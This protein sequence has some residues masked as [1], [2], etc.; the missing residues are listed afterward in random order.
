MMH[1]IFVGFLSIVIVYNLAN[2]Q[3]D[4]C[5]TAA[6]IGTLGA[7][8]ACPNENGPIQTYNYTTVGATP[9]SPYISLLN[10]NGAPGTGDDMD[11]PAGDVWIRFV[12]SGTVLDVSITS[13]MS[14]MNVG[15]YTGSCGAL[16]GAFCDISTNGNLTTTFEPISPG[17]TY[18]M[19]ISG[20]STTD[21]GAFTLSLE[22]S[23]NCD[24]CNTASTITATPAPVNGFYAPNTTVTFCY[25][26]TNFTQITNNWL[27][28]VVPTFGPGWN[29]ST[30]TPAAPTP[31]SGSIQGT[32]Y[33]WQWD[34]GPTGTG[35]WVDVDPNGPNP[36]DGN[37]TNNFG[38]PTI[39]GSGNWPFCWTI[40]TDAN[41]TQGNDLSM[42]VNTTSDG[43]TGNWNSPA[44]LA[45]P[46]GSFTSTLLCCAT[47][48]NAGTDASVCTT[49]STQ[50]GGSYSN[51]TGS[52]T[53]SWTASPASALTGLSST[54]SLNPTF[55]PPAGLTG[56]VTF[57]LSVTDAACTQTDAVA[58]TIVGPPTISGGTSVCLNNSL[59]LSG[60]GTPATNN[61]WTSSNP[62][63]ATI[64]SGGVVTGVSVGSTTITYTNSIGCSNTLTL[65]VLSL[66][67]ISGT[68]TICGTGTTQLTGSGTPA[69]S[70]PWTSSNNSIATV[71]SSGLVTGIA[72]GTVNITYTNSAGCSKTESITVLPLPTISGNTSVCINNTTQ[73]N[74]SGT[75]ATTNPWATSSASIATVSGTGLVTGVAAGTTSITYT[76]ADGCSVTIPV[77]VNALPTISGTLNACVGLSSNL[78]GSGVASTTNPWTSSNATIAT[79][80]SSGTVTAVSIGSV[81]ITYTNSNGCSVSVNF[82]VNPLPTIS[83]T[84]NV[85]L[86][87]SITLSGT[88]TASATTPWQSSN[89][90]VA[91]VNST[92]VV[93]GASVGNSNITYTNSNGCQASALVAVLALPSVSGT[94]NTCAGNSSTLTG[95]GTPS[96][97]S[98]WISSNAAVATVSS[99]GVV[100][101][102]SAGTTNITYTNSNG[103][104]VTV[105]FTVNPNPTIN[106]A[107][108]SCLPGSSLLTG[109]GTPSGTNPWVSS[110]TTSST[111]NASG[112]VTAVS[113]GTSTITYTNSSGCQVSAVFTV[114]ANPTITGTPSVCVGATSQLT[115]SGAAASVN[116]WVSSSTIIATVNSTG[117]VS[118]LSPGTTTITF[119]D[120]NGCQ[121]NVTFTVNAL[122]SAAIS[123]GNA[124]C[125]GVTPAPI[126][127]SV[128]GSP[129]WTVTYTLNGTPGSISG[130][131]SPIS[132]GNTAGTYVL[133]GISDALCS[134]SAS[135]TQVI[136]FSPAPI[137]SLSSN[138]PTVCNGT[139]GSIVVSG[140]GNGNL[141]W[142]G[143]ISGSQTNITLPF[144]ISNLNAGTY[145]VTFTNTA[146]GCSTLPT[147]ASLN[148]PGAP[149]INVINDVS[150]CG[151]SYTLPV[152]TGVSL[153]NA[154]YYTLPGGPSGGGTVV[155]SGTVLSTTGTVSLYAYD[156]NGACFD[157]EP[158]TVTIQALPNATLSGGGTFCSG[159][160]ISPVIAN[161]TGT[162]PFTIQY[163]L[164]G[165]TFTLNSSSLNQSLGTNAGSYTLLSVS[166]ANCSNTVNGSSSITINPLPSAVITGGGTYCANQAVTPVSVTTTGS[167][168]WL[169]NYTLNGTAQ[170]VSGNSSPISL[171]SSAGTYTITTVTDANCSS[172]ANG[173]A[174]IIIHPLPSATISGGGN[175]CLGTSPTPIS[176]NLSGSPQ[177]SITY[178]ID[179]VPTTVNTSNNVLNVGS[180]AG[181]YTLVSLTDA[182]CS[183]NISGTQS[184]SITSLPTATISG[185]AT[186]CAGEII[187]N[188]VAAVSGAGNW[189]VNYTLNGVPA[190]ASANSSPITIGNTAGTYVLTGISDN[191]CNAS[192]TGSTSIVINPLPT[193]TILGGG[194]FC[195]GNTVN[196]VQVSFTG[197]PSWTLNYTFNGVPQ[198]LN[199]AGNSISLGTQGGTYVLTG[200]SDAVCNN[201]AVGSQDIV[202]NALPSATIT[203]GG[204]F[205]TGS[206]ITPVSA[207]VTG[208]GNWQVSYTLNGIPGTA[209]GNSSPIQ[210]NTASGNYLL[211]SVSD[212]NCTNTA[213]GNTEIVVLPLPTATLSGGATYCAGETIESILVTV[214]GSPNFTIDYLLDGVPGTVLGTTNSFPLGTTAGT[215]ALVG[216]SDASCSNT[217]NGSST[218]LIHPIPA[219]SI[220]GND[221]SVCNATDGFVT[222]TGLTA[223]NT[224]GLSYTVNGNPAAD[225]LLSDATG[226]F[227]ISGLTAGEYAA[228][229]V[230][231]LSTDCQGTNP[232]VITLI[233]PGAPF[234]DPLQD[235]IGCDSIVLPGISGQNLTVNVGYFTGIN[236]TGIQYQPGD[237][238]F[239]GDSL[240]IFDGIGTCTAQIGLQVVVDYTPELNQPADLVSCGTAELPVIT[241]NNLSGN[242]T[243][244]DDAQA[245]GGLP[246]IGNMITQS[247][248]I[249]IYDAVNGCSDETSF[250][251]TIHPLPVLDSVFGG[252][253]YC[254][255]DDIDSVAVSVSGE[256]P[257]NVVFSLNGTLDTLVTQTTTF[258]IGNT[259]GEYEV[260][261][262][263]SSNCST[264]VDGL[265]SIIVNE[266]PPAPQT[267][268]DTTYCLNWTPVEMS[269]QGSGGQLT[270]YAD[271]TFSTIIDETPEIVAGTT[272]YYVIEELNGCIG[273][274]SAV[275]I[276][277]NACEIE[278]P[279][280]FTPDG[281]FRN[282]IWQI[283]DIDVI[284]PKNIVRIYNRWGNLL[285]ESAEGSY[286]S[287]PWNGR[288]DDQPLPVGSYYFIIELNEP[289]LEPLKGIVSI[290]LN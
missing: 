104:P 235:I 180:A 282:D 230:T 102:I 140:S 191:A 132:L 248:T 181:T 213:F 245:A 76:N 45:D 216:I 71:S 150:L 178:T 5:A 58:V 106:G 118:G 159:N 182:V 78:T 112:L 155:P 90:A 124:Y 226:S 60:T 42:S 147:T 207:Q 204:T 17:T 107:L 174:N 161:L 119:T 44:C 165:N 113:P 278:I 65:N 108:S 271:S 261:S 143:S 133:T 34:T 269:A 166:D 4:N 156:A 39:N 110:N 158:F 3:G 212:A 263:Y 43:E 220:I 218:I 187:G 170:T 179:G 41:C 208:V 173:N 35:W 135:G 74:G 242:A 274:A 142:S 40:T 186:Y 125:A 67:T 52:V 81:T 280:A 2:G 285:F 115:G 146:T 57:T 127:V 189:T 98:P 225:T 272:T 290:I 233:N 48:V 268:G 249:W 250:V 97:S 62:A 210:L 256:T 111:I 279:T 114:Q 64:T 32:D 217:A 66:P 287:E 281:D 211:T 38:M 121:T 162:S 7:P 28:G 199:S 257:L 139:N 36:P 154:Q 19:Q 252:G 79:V 63:V 33:V 83:G 265:Q 167:G 1:K 198:T 177:F 197:T 200:I 16:S 13:S 37:P 228:F 126:N 152:I 286:S 237:V 163:S 169:I 94:L 253:S 215:Y 130:I 171:G 10:C 22:N 12:A 117:L 214:T 55:T 267:S 259:P 188:V 56:T 193:A 243:Y 184:I 194:T 99:G 123:G 234:I 236:G 85:C 30:L 254:V 275:Q 136:S 25:T 160:A 51:T 277:F 50:L 77:T 247:G 276:T 27:H 116:P 246:I 9:S 80:N 176:I 196:P 89:P 122:P 18:Y 209:N 86:G 227:N 192:A 61:P 24:I 138:D 46:V 105:V 221:P 92:G 109:S 168:S 96:S 244:F 103:C 270:W 195:S 175:V 82:I 101:G 148:N 231:D 203:G 15:L 75:P 283:P 49:G 149:I 205:C 29:P 241:G 219:F 206:A 6:N 273:P 91:T 69:S 222:F 21:L 95:S 144:T 239:A 87:N 260:I 201:V 224:Y 70:N 11:A 266:L 59:T 190:T 88:A 20:G 14:Q 153:N 31:A 284:F 137:I 141:T 47:L 73:L 262:V 145:S 164:N 151:G 120:N 157:E 84:L 258:S 53:T 229:I 129:A 72:P 255:G 232:T 240:F 54:T 100:N 93:T 202:I 128:S 185:G 238:L 172:S 251:V 26:I 68:L 183:N 134:N 131:S 223:N 289:N 288:Y 23:N 264:D 8:F